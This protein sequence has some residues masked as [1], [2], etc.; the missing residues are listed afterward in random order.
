M[1]DPVFESLHLPAKK[2]KI[3]IRHKINTPIAFQ[4]KLQNYTIGSSLKYEINTHL[5]FTI[6][7]AVLVIKLMIKRHRY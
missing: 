6:R 2:K 1:V 3:I 4:Y 5:T 7:S